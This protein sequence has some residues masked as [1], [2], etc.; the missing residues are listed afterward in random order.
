MHWSRV[1]REVVQS[2]SLVFKESIDV[3][4]RAWLVG[5]NGGRQTVGV[6]DVRGLF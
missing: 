6:D 5:S 1:P 4:P 3:A 2:P